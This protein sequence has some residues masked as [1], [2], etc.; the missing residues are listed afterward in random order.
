MSFTV[1]KPCNLNENQLKE[2]K[3]LVEVCN[4][5]DNLNYSVDVDDSFKEPEEINTF[6]LYLDNTLV[7]YTYLFTPG[8]QEAEVSAF[9]L[10][11]FRLRGY[12]LRLL[13]DAGQEMTKRGIKDFLFVCD[14]K[15]GTG[16][17]AVKHFGAE[18]EYSEYS[19]RYEK[20]SAPENRKEPLLTIRKSGSG[21]REELIE[22]AK[23][24]LNGNVEEA[25]N[26]VT[27]I[28]SSDNRIQHVGVFEGKI[29]GM[30]SV[31]R[32]PGKSYIHGLCVFPEYRKQG[33]GGELIGFKVA[34]SLAFDSSYVIELEV[35]TDNRSALSIYERNGFK[36]IARYDYFRKKIAELFIGNH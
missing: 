24:S 29:A 8:K 25:E 2:M 23:I 3:E 20:P 12:F 26:Y 33:L 7:S 16:L 1:K 34:E 17:S 4:R 10:P 15:S 19:M 21:D 36:I 32:E 30:V 27:S 11:N 14:D 22:L 9:T 13:E 28:F 18:Y 35:Q 6:L 5:H 31:Y